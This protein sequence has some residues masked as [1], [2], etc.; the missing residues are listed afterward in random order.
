MNNAIYSA[1]VDYTDFPGQK[2]RVC[3]GAIDRKDEV[4]RVRDEVSIVRG[5]SFTL[6]ALHLVHVKG[7]PIRL[8][9]IFVGAF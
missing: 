4:R 7:V 2:F 5:V 8:A 6:S 1:A 3:D 9:V